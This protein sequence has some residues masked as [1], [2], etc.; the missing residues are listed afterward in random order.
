MEVFSIVL[1]DSQCYRI[2]A[3]CD[4]L[5]NNAVPTSSDMG[6]GPRLMLVC[7]RWVGEFIQTET[8]RESLPLNLHHKWRTRGRSQRRGDLRLKEGEKEVICF[9]YFEDINFNVVQGVY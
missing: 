5:V 7:S 1:R 3:S 9:R 4:P 8:K 2:I 6:P